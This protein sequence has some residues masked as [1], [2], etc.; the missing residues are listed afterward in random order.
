MARRELNFAI[1]L[2]A[3]V[4]L[5]GLF[6]STTA[7]LWRPWL[8]TARQVA[9]PPEVTVALQ[10][11]DKA[12][13]PPPKPDEFEMGQATGHGIGSNASTGDRLL[14][15]READEDQALLSRNPG[16]SGRLVDQQR[17]DAPPGENGSGGQEGGSIA[18]QAAPAAPPAA[19]VVV[20]APASPP[21]AVKMTAQDPTATVAANADAPIDPPKVAALLTPAQ[22]P[23]EPSPPAVAT[24]N[25]SQ[26][27]RPR[28]GDGRAPGV[29]LRQSDPAQKSDSESDPFAR[30][31]SLVFHDGILE[32]QKGR[33]VKTTRPRVLL[34]G[35]VD[36]AARGGATV[37]LSIAV[38][39]TGKVT[40][41]QILHSSGSNDIDQPC[42]VA[43]YDWWF[44]PS[45]DKQGRPIADVL[46]FTIRFI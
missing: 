8:G 4:A 14:A 44:E 38:D 40:S 13:L 39:P 25:A 30:I 34:P 18:Q 12:A 28:T 7:R 17:P 33:K 26:S 35:E 27:I 22:I 6:L 37:V 32:V 29:D 16:S 42:R 11:P 23:K 20:Q 19:A 10:D 43:V 45:R 24:N 5:H 36:L 3:S 41:A 1:A 2:G 21:P 31:G 9:A 46:T 15:A